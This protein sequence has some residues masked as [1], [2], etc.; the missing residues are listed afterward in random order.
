VTLPDYAV[1]VNY[2]VTDP[3]LSFSSPDYSSPSMKNGRIPDLRN[4]LFW[5]PLLKPDK[6]GKVKTEFWSSDYAAD[7]VINI[8]G[9][10]ENG[11]FISAKKKIRVY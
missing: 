1:R 6:E 5:N 7:Y 2:R 8:Q 10:N 3:T 11:E 9:I 4:T